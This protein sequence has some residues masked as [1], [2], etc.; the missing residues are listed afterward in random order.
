MDVRFLLSGDR[1]ASLTLTLPPGT[2]PT[3]LFNQ[4]VLP[5]HAVLRGVRGPRPPREIPRIADLVRDAPFPVYGLLDTPYDLACHGLGYGSSGR[6]GNQPPPPLAGEGVGGEVLTHISFH[7]R[8]PATAEDAQRTVELA[9]SGVDDASLPQVPDWRVHPLETPIFDP[10]GFQY[11]R[12]PDLAALHAA[13]APQPPYLIDRFPIAGAGTPFAARLQRW[14]Q[15]H[16]EWRFSLIG[17]TVHLGGTATGFSQ[18]ELLT[19]LEL[20][21]GPIAGKPD[22]L[23]HYQ[24]AFDDRRR[25]FRKHED[26]S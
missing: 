17:D 9:S 11:Q 14:R 12:Y 18:D 26:Q 20:H 2:H 8:S 22:L 16:D 15:P 25:H 24:T 13:A 1:I 7:F 10:D 3:P 23:A 21:L 4:P 19:L 5:S 6:P